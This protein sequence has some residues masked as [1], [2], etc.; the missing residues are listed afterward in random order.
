MR[1]IRQY[2]PLDYDPEVEIYDNPAWGLPGF[3]TSR[4]ESSKSTGTAKKEKTRR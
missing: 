3:R 2:W 4:R 1:T